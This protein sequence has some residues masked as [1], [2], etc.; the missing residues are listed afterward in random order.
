MDTRCTLLFNPNTTQQKLATGLRTC[1][2]KSLLVLFV[3]AAFSLLLQQVYADTDRQPGDNTNNPYQSQHGAV[4]LL[5]DNGV[6][7]EALQMQSDVDIAITGAVAR[8][9]VSQSF[10]N[11]GAF[12]A[13]GVYVFPLP[14]KAAV[15]QFRLKIGER[16]IESRVEERQAARAS[17]Q[18]ARAAGKKTSLLEQQRPNVF[19]TSLAN[20]A[21]GENITVEFSYQQRLD[22]KDQQY[23]LRFPLVVGPRYHPSAQ[24]GHGTDRPSQN[25]TSVKTETDEIDMNR[26]PTRIH[27][28]LDAGVSLAALESRYH[29]IDIRQTSETRYSIATVGNRIRTDRDFELIWKPL[30]GDQPHLGAVTQTRN[31]ESYTM[32]TLLPPDLSYLQ[33]QVRARE[34]I[35]VL[36]ISGSMGGASIRQAKA[37]LLKA[38]A[39]LN[40]VDRFN[41]VWFNDK[42]GRLFP[43]S[44]PAKKHFIE[45]A[46]QF[47]HRIEANGGTEMLPAMELALS[48]QQPY[49]RFRQVVFLTDGNISNEAELFRL[50]DAQLGESRLF[51]VGIGAAPNAYFMR[52][53]AGKGRGSFTYI[54]DINEV[55]EKTRALFEKLEHPALVNISLDLDRQRYEIFPENIPDL[56]AGESA[57]IVLKGSPPPAQVT[58]T[59]DYG[60]SEWRSSVTIESQKIETRDAN[61][62]DTGNNDAETAS[63]VSLDQLWA[64]EKIEALMTQYQQTSHEPVRLRLKQA[65]TDTAIRHHLVS[66]FTS[67]VA[68][69]VTPVNANGLLYRQKMK[70][71]LPHGWS[72]ASGGQTIMLAQTAAGWRLHLL[73]AAVFFTGACLLHGWRRSRTSIQA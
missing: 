50:I 15:D 14:E 11:T 6:Y 16:I 32:L 22:Y 44:Q 29:K 28:L 41:L 23:R 49:E 34:V 45:F 21:P 70:N 5:P 51:T 67:L 69:D 48:Q 30:T 39:R 56:Y 57:T 1:V 18:R 68:V 53:A 47:V 4:W 26:N 55:E 36:D 62:D 10:K 17:Y 7:I 24:T 9:H 31:G 63:K 38:L 66:R 64:R 20:I 12:W 52:K 73:M 42:A 35:F 60:H 46:R 2:K 54:G 65:V 58:I 43:H 8:T 33:Q 72:Q 27:I 37:A 59:G 71:N 19:T 3:Y 61:N 25:D 40:S 13:E